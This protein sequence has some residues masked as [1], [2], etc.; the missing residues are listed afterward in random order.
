[1]YDLHVSKRKCIGSKLDQIM[2]AKREYHL[3][4]IVLVF[5]C[6]VKIN[7]ISALLRALSTCLQQSEIC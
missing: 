1:M 5:R 6:L 3:L 2:D 4:T 7:D